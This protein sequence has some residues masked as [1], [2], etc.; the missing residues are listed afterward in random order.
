M[1]YK[2]KYLNQAVLNNSAANDVNKANDT[3]DTNK[4]FP[5]V[6]HEDW[7]YTDLTQLLQKNF[8]LAEF[9]DLSS[10][11]NDDLS[12]IEKIK[13]HNEKI[14]EI[15]PKIN[16]IN[17]LDGL[18]ISQICSQ[19][20]SDGIVLRKNEF[21]A[22]SQGAR[23]AIDAKYFIDFIC[24]TSIDGLVI[25]VYADS[26]LRINF[27]YTERSNNKIINNNNILN[28]S[29]G[30]NVNVIEEYIDLTEES[31]VE[32]NSNSILE[33][34]LE[35]KANVVHYIL[36]GCG[37]KH[38]KIANYFVNQKNESCYTN[39][40]LN[41]GAKLARQDI[42]VNQNGD[43]ADSSLFGLYMP[44]N[45][46]HVD[47]HLKIFHNGS[48]GSS[49]QD[50]RGVLS[51]RAR[52]VWNGMVCVASGTAANNAIQ[53]NKNLSLSKYAQVDTKPELQIYSDDVSCSHGATIGALDNKALFYLQSR[54]VSKE[55][56][57]RML[58]SGFVNYIIERIKNPEVKNWLS[59]K[60]GM[61]N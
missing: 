9:S 24:R 55:D 17:F 51:D 21:T 48:F 47:A 61:S 32:V 37:Y 56:G 7:K 39:Y 22:G 11:I 36:Q 12:V 38:Y 34:N 33:I 43:Y 58:I 45:A 25:D 57:K 27:Y 50:Y 41:F 59:D 13:S 4:L 23:N 29:C 1:I 18:Y 3:D 44:Q 31:S 16:I 10:E 26:D 60:Y 35:N 6:S 28:I 20:I 5:N 40:N 42:I 15:N 19:N 8:K 53:S 54:G 52:G 46:Q 2:K 49:K 14:Y 30:I